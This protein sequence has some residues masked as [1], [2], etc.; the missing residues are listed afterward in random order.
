MKATDI[1]SYMKRIIKAL[2]AIIGI[3][4]IAIVC[5]VYGFLHYLSLYD[6]TSG[7]DQNVSDI[8]NI[9]NSTIEQH[10]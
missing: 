10:S 5:I 2:I 3:L 4:V 7:T 9:E 1:I 8:N 6:F